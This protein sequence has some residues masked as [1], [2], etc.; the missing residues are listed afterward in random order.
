[1]K[2]KDWVPPQSINEVKR[3]G[4]K[5]PRCAVKQ[6]SRAV[7]QPNPHPMILGLA[8]R[9]PYRRASTWSRGNVWVSLTL[10][11][12]HTGDTRKLGAR[13]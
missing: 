1:M 10:R 9:P 7:A 13:R 3:R 11:Q 12:S 4:G 6:K 2:N 8:S 5:M